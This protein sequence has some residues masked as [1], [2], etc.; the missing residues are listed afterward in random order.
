LSLV[1]VL[2]GVVALAALVFFLARRG[3]E[4]PPLPRPGFDDGEVRRSLE[5]LAAR[6]KEVSITDDE[7]TLLEMFEKLNRAETAEPQGPET[8]RQ[9]EGMVKAVGEV[10]LAR[11]TRN[12]ERY[13]RLGDSMAVEFD[14]AL[15]AVL[16]RARSGGLARALES[17]A[18]DDLRRLG[19]SFVKRAVERE[20]IDDSGEIDGPAHLAQ[21]LF[22]VRWRAIAGMDRRRGLSPVEWLAHMD[23]ALTFSRPESVE[24]RLQAIDE[25]QKLGP[26]FDALLARAIVLHEAGMS[27]EALALLDE[28]IAGGRK[29][30]PVLDF[31]RFLTP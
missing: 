10:A 7:R 8:A 9:V 11:A 5:E 25:I 15:N 16:E 13:L 27:G 2:L 26:G 24:L 14:R 19:G 30:E 21:V 4:I 1:L 31:A 6:A 22:R 12:P 3:G 17:E 20:L 18:G 28:A 29:D 23:F